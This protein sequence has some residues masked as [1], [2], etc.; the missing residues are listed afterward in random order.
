MP[1]LLGEE[2][3]TF[4]DVTGG[5]FFDELN[6]HDPETA[7]YACAD[8]DYALR[9]YHRFNEWLDS[10]L[11]LHRWIVENAERLTAVYCGLMKYNGLLMDKPA[12]IRKQGECATRLLE[13]REQ[14]RGMIGNVDVGANAGTQAF[15]DYLSR[16]SA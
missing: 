13:L 10:F 4:E 7:R 15:K 11:L 5:R 6:S 1:E 9:L 12:M 16:N 8:S 2:L 14:I 3:P